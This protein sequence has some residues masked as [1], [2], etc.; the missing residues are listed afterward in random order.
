MSPW[1]AAAKALLPYV[2]E[3]ATATIPVL[4]RR[5]AKQD[6]DPAQQISELQTAVTQN[7]EAIK[8]LAEQTE[9]TVQALEHG[10]VEMERR[11]RRAQVSALIA[12]AA[13]IVAVIVALAAL[14]Q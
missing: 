4:T 7:G 1:L 5:K 3:I 6:V 8:L 14:M 10:A 9:K 11:L 2:A 13:A 12:G